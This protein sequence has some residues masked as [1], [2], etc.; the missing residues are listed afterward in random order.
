MIKL[1]AFDLW[2]TLACKRFQSLD[3]IRQVTGTRIPHDQF[4]KVFESS[5]QL[6]RWRSKRKAYRN[7]LRNMGLRPTESL[8]KDIR[9]IRED[10]ASSITVLDHS[11][12]MLKEIRKKGIALGLITNSSVFSVRRLQH[13]SDLLDYFDHRQFSYDIGRIKPDPIVF[14]RMMKKAKVSPE[15]VLM[16]GDNYTDDVLPARSLGMHAIH[17]RGKKQL[18]TD[19]RKLNIRLRSLSDQ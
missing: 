5:V 14:I 18:N 13:Q 7:L 10:S 12:P 15:E 17:F 11:I 3:K 8:V 16:I 6:K 19:L 1:V 4:V 9:I 2:N